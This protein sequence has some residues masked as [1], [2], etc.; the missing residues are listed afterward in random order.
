MTERE[1]EAV[2]V[3][4]YVYAQNGHVEKALRLLQALHAMDPRKAI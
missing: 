3:L 4:A 1:R 2:T